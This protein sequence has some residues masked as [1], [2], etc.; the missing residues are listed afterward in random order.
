MNFELGG[1]G[2]QFSPWLLGAEQA[3]QSLG[4]KV[5]PVRALSPPPPGIGG[6]R[7]AGCTQ[8][9]S[10]TPGHLPS[11]LPL[12]SPSLSQMERSLLQLLRFLP[13]L[14]F[15]CSEA[16]FLSHKSS[17]N[18]IPTALTCKGIF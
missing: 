4:D 15:P 6:V 3:A 2:T 13:D 8:G 16:Q 18:Y 17:V 5:G 1:V 7:G 11:L 9:L 12:P 10:H 14:G